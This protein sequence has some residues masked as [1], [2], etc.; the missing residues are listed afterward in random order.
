ML[1]QKDV[2]RFDV[3]VD[4]A[5]L[6]RARER[7]ADLDEDAARVFEADLFAAAQAHL[8]VLAVEQ[9][10]DDVGDFR[11]GRRE[12]QDAHDVRAFDSRGK[13]GFCAEARDAAGIFRQILR[14]E[15]HGDGRVEPQVLGDPDVAHA[16][17]AEHRAETDVV[18]NEHARGELVVG[19]ALIDELEHVGIDVHLGGVIGLFART[20]QIVSR[21]H[22]NTTI[23][24]G[25]LES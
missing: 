8:E 20:I 9:L 5:E 6:V 15:L 14:H 7:L 23:V 13:L 19:C 10:H 18:R 22:G 11:D 12:I 1:R 25:K 4:D 2:V 3:A 21:V 17:R 16:A 24:L